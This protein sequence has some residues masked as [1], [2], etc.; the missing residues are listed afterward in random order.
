M[1]SR[2]IGLLFLLISAVATAKDKRDSV[3]PRMRYS[4]VALSFSYLPPGEML[5]KTQRVRAEVQARAES[6]HTKD[7]LE[8]LLAMSSG[9]DDAATNWHSLTLETYPRNAVA[10]V[11]DT[12]AEAKMSAWVAHSQETHPVS[13]FVV[14][15]GQSFAVSIFGVQEGPIKKGA[16]VWTTIRKGKLLSFA[17]VANSPQQLMKLAETMKTVEFF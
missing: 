7:A 9:Q 14:I 16:V 8:A 12:V 5:D 3:T 11:D 10:D 1:N 17:F 4:N 15:S 6:S 2:S 13:R